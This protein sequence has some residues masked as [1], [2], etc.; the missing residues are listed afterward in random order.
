MNC[1]VDETTNLKAKIARLR[2]KS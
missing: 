2:C 1:V